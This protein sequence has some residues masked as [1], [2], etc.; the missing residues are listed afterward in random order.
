MKKCTFKGLISWKFLSIKIDFSIEK[1]ISKILYKSFS[2]LLK[3]IIIFE[4]I[5]KL[6]I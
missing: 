6:Y 4:T 2:T 5:R 3:Y 1:K